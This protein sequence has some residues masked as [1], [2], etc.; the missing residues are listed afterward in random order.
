MKSIIRKCLSSNSKIGFN[1]SRVCSA[2]S[3]AFEIKKYQI[4][5]RLLINKYNNSLLFSD[6][7]KQ[8]NSRGE[9][10]RSNWLGYGSCKDFCVAL[11][12]QYSL[13]RNKT[14]LS[15]TSFNKFMIGRQ[16]QY[17]YRGDANK[18]VNGYPQW[19]NSLMVF[20][21]VT[22]NSATASTPTLTRKAVN[23]Q[24]SEFNIANNSVYDTCFIPEQVKKVETPEIKKVVKRTVYPPYQGDK[25]RISRHARIRI[26][27]LYPGSENEILH[28]CKKS[29][30]KLN[31]FV[32]NS[33]F[34]Y[35]IPK[36]DLKLIIRNK[37]LIAV[38][39]NKF[40]MA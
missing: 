34:S 9:L 6:V 12:P 20:A 14:G 15:L 22:P 17:G 27:S 29:F 35:I 38:A 33:E 25:L 8:I 3:S 10:S 26:A 7:G 18:F 5:L 30:I 28:Y 4:R 39:T 36:H 37:M 16:K 19:L 11:L 2:L 13:N 21:L 32:G 23:K 40:E 1:V 24:Y 31:D